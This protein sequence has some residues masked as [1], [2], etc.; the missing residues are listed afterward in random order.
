MVPPPSKKTRL[1]EETKS[2]DSSEDIGSETGIEAENNYKNPPMGENPK[3]DPEDKPM[4][5]VVS[6]KRDP[7]S[8]GDNKSPEEEKL[9]T[10]LE[11]EAELKSST[12]KTKDNK[13]PSG[14]K[15][16]TKKEKTDSPVEKV[17]GMVGLLSKD[18]FELTPHLFNKTSKATIESIQEIQREMKELNKLWDRQLVNNNEQEELKDL[19]KQISLDFIEYQ[20]LSSDY[21]K[22][23]E[24]MREFKE[25]HLGYQKKK[26]E[27]I[28]VLRL[29]LDE[30]QKLSSNV[31]NIIELSI[32]EIASEKDIPLVNKI[33]DICENKIGYSF[34]ALFLLERLKESEKLEEKYPNQFSQVFKYDFEGNIAQLISLNICEAKKAGELYDDEIKELISYTNSKLKGWEI[35]SIDEKGAYS[36]KTQVSTGVANAAS[37]I[38]EIFTLPVKIA[39]QAT[40]HTDV[41][42]ALVSAK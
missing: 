8:S 22:L 4:P 26:M 28:K 37:R 25:G 2:R 21:K 3:P 18:K 24:D 32:N 12:S 39:D 19:K 27:E 29:E 15:K 5:K 11:K 30:S 7:E 20:K 35:L 9:K 1:E 36:D 41:K 6:T 34:Y 42:R 23:N 17:L 10:P 13:K 33:I 16:K 14:D 40:N 38:Q 31:K